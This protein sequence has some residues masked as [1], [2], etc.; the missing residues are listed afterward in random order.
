MR[1]PLLEVSDL[2][3][4]TSRDQEPI[5]DGVDFTLDAGEALG[6][7]GE[8]GSGKTTTALALMKLLPPAL[9]AGPPTAGFFGTWRSVWRARGGC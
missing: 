5:V 9:K 8:S 6:L 3:V 1:T 7:A 4:V 2:R